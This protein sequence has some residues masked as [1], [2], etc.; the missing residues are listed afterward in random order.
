MGVLFKKG[1]TSIFGK[2][3]LPT[4]FKYDLIHQP[5]IYMLEAICLQGLSSD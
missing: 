3:I 5:A 2:A 4:A 1:F